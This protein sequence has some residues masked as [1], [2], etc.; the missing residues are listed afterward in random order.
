MALRAKRPK[1]LRYRK[2]VSRKYERN[3]RLRCINV[4]IV[5]LNGCF[6]LL[7]FSKLSNVYNVGTRKF[8]VE[9]TNDFHDKRG[10][11]KKT[12]IN[13][14]FWLLIKSI[15]FFFIGYNWT[16]YICNYEAILLLNNWMFIFESQLGNAEENFTFILYAMAKGD[17]KM[18]QL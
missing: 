10:I 16:W 15:W 3:K 17:L 13:I 18:K 9:P 12:L 4:Y 6:V 8:A 1:R 11:S 7:C 14:Q 2:N 5:L